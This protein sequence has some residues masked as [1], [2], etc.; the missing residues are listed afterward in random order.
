MTIA[1]ACVAGSIAG[2]L[3]AST[4][5]QAC[6]GWNCHVSDWV[7]VDNSAS[8]TVRI[9]HDL[10]VLPKELTVWFSPSATGENARLVTWSWSNGNSGNPVAIGADERAIRIEIFANASIA[11][12]WNASTGAWTLHDRGYFR[13]VARR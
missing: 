11:G 13:T 3:A 8:R 6:P 12:D 4:F 2:Y 7:P 1:G 10:G 9:A 5:G